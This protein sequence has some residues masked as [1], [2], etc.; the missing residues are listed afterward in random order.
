ME[1]IGVVVRIIL[2]CIFTEWGYGSLDWID[3]AWIGA[4]ARH[5]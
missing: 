5:L 3:L 1:D 4:V 2:R